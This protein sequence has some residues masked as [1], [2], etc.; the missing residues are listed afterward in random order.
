MRYRF[1]ILLAAFFLMLTAGVW[2]WQNPGVLEGRLTAQEI[3]QYMGV[4][5]RLPF[6][7]DERE[8]M[9]RSARAWM[10]SD[11]ARPVYMLN[12]MRFYPELRRYDGGR[13]FNGTPRESN[14]LYEALVRPLLLKRGGYPIFGGTA[15]GSNLLVNEPALDN[16][17]RVL[18][19][20]Y[21]SRRDFLRV[22]SVP[23]FREALPYKVMALRIVLTPTTRDMGIPE[24]P[25]LVGTVLLVVFLAV[26]WRRALLRGHLHA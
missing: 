6:P 3:D 26:G 24:L 22:M 16:W 20:R 23:A 13:E 9:L 4:L 1:E 21:S 25:G 10:E 5:S 18:V 17:N 19:V 11:D 2:L 14:A 8:D 7:S 15:Q 12:L